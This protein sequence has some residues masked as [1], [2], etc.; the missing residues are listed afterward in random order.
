LS[1]VRRSVFR[2]AT[3][4]EPLLRPVGY[5]LP[6]AHLRIYYYGTWSQARFDRAC[7]DITAELTTRGLRPEHRVLDVGSGIGNV[8]IGLLD[9]LRGGYDGIDVHSEAVEWCQR[10]ITTRHPTFR[11]HRA[12][13]TSGA[14]NPHGLAEASTYRFPFDDGV[15]DFV[16]LASV[17]THLEPAPLEQYLREVARLLAPSGVCVASY[18]LLNEETR[19]GVQDGRSFMSFD[20]PHPSGTCLLHDA[21]RP[22]SAIAFDEDYVRQIH[23]SAGLTISN[24]RRGGWWAGVPHEQDVLTV[25]HRIS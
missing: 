6:P 5:L 12:N 3:L 10:S 22:E 2:F 14:Y 9:Y 1:Q 20:V 24:V 18:F 11:F 21:G 7:K 4:V 13:L 17:F 25:V 23:E 15:F 8:A 19:R 16:L